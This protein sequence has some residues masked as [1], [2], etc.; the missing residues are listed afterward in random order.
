[1]DRRDPIGLGVSAVASIEEARHN[2][3][4]RRGKPAE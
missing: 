2:H 1:M 4:D 3:H